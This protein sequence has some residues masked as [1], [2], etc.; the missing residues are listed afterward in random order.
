MENALSGVSATGNTTPNENLKQIRASAKRHR[1]PQLNS[2]NTISKTLSA[3][4]AADETAAAKDAQTG[5]VERVKA[6][7]SFINQ[8]YLE[9]GCTDTQDTQ[10]L[11]ELVAKFN[12]FCS[13]VSQKSDEDQL[14]A[15]LLGS[16][17]TSISSVKTAKMPIIRKK[18]K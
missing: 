10:E 6:L 15:P 14:T 3:T 4:L 2:E 18:L 7:V 17:K 13:K 12:T 11:K 8:Y 5:V 1:L 16:T 9:E